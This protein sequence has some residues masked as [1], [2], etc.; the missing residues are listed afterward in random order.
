MGGSKEIVL[1]FLQGMDDSEQF[2]VIDVIVLFRR[3]QRL[4]QVH[5]G[6]R[7]LVESFCIKTALVAVSEVSDMTK[8]GEVM[9]GMA[10]TGRRVKA[11]LMVRKASSQ[12]GV[13]SHQVFL[14]VR[15]WRGRCWKSRK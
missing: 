5:T 1:P 13:Q 11:S 6:I 4:G 8:N 12:E 7:S 15:S 14:L 9:S 10:R 3:T 2:T